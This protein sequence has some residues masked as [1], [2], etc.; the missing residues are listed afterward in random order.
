MAIQNSLD[1]TATGVITHDGSGV[2][3]GS[4]ITQYQTLVAGASNAISGISVGTS[5]QVLTSNGAGSNP[6]Y[7]DAAGGGGGWV[8]LASAT[9]SSSATLDFSSSID[10]T[11]NCY[12]FI[13]DH[14]APA[15]DGASFNVRTST[16]GGSTYDSTGYYV[17]KDFSTS[18]SNVGEINVTEFI[19]NNTNESTS[20][21]VYL[22]NPSATEYTTIMSIT[23][24]RTST[25]ALDSGIN[26]GDRN[27]AADVDAIRFLM[28]SGNIASGTVSMYGVCTPS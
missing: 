2:F 14:I 26:I 13:V 23:R 27:S 9:A 18:N 3:T 7:Q 20:G 10:A 24:K 1:L 28:S 17:S 4:A 12:A 5:G 15:T 25:N 11:Y 21:I 8:F 22:I 16:D 19:G 6:T